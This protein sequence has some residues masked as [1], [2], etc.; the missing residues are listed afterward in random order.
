M[1]DLG[2]QVLYAIATGRT[3]RSEITDAVGTEPPRTLD[4]LIAL[5]L[6]RRQPGDLL[7]AMAAD[8]FDTP[9]AT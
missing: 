1:G 2:R 7:T 8:I 9:T 5:R 6:D 3:K 4:R